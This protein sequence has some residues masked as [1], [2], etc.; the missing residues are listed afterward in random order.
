MWALD[1]KAPRADAPVQA[2]SR[3]PRWLPGGSQEPSPHSPIW[4]LS[5]R[6]IVGPRAPS[7]AG[8]PGDSWKTWPRALSAGLQGPRRLPMTIGPMV[9]MTQVVGSFGIPVLQ[10]L[11]PPFLT[12]LSLQQPWWCPWPQALDTSQ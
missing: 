7:M 12:H 2:D 9:L 11:F 8:F 3:S 4:C 5:S 10:A 6:L 1:P